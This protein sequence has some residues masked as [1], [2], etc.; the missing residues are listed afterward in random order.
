MQYRQTVL[1]MGRYTI[2]ELLFLNFISV[3]FFLSGV[4]LDPSVDACLRKH[5]TLHLSTYQY[6]LHP[7][8]FFLFFLTVYF[9]SLL[10][11]I[12]ALLNFHIEY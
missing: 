10:R 5:I 1:E 6:V 11:S 2:P 7:L 8:T 4:G 9:A 3:H 12:P